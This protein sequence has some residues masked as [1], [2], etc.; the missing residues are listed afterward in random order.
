MG[1]TFNQ[2]LRHQLENSGLQPQHIEAVMPVIMESE[3][4]S[5]MKGRWNDQVDGYP[6]GFAKLIMP[7]ARPLVYKWISENI[8]H[9]WFRAAFAPG[10]EKCVIATDYEEFVKNFWRENPPTK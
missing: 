7:L 1:Q 6:M 10:V 3:E 8:P 9:A 5:N 2:Y 4:M